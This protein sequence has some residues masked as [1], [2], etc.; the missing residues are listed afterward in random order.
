[1]MLSP[2]DIVLVSEDAD[3]HIGARHAGQLDSAGE[4]LVTLGIIVLQAN[5]KLDSL[6]K[7]AFLLVEGVLEEGLHVGTHPGFG[8]LGSVVN[9]L[10]EFVAAYRL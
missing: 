2:I 3:A 7:V 4:T 1:M 8:S 6:K 10:K 5:L 9:C